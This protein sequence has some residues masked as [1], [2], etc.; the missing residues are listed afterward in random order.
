MPIFGVPLKTGY[1]QAILTEETNSMWTP[2]IIMGPGVKKQNKLAEPINHL[3]QL[4]TIL[5]LMGIPVPKIVEGKVL[6]VIEE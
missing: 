5:T 2:F 1:K 3:D 6:D 4:P